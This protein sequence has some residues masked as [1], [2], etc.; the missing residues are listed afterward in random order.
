MKCLDWGK[1]CN[2]CIWGFSFPTDHFLIWHGLWPLCGVTQ[3]SH[4]M[5]IFAFFILWK[6]TDQSFVRVWDACLWNWRGAC[7]MGFMCPCVCRSLFSQSL[8]KVPALGLAHA[9]VSVCLWTFI[10]E[11]M[12]KVF[13]VSVHK[14]IYLSRTLRGFPIPPC[15]Q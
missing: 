4:K 9:L 6:A 1:C 3:A 7:E 13:L 12:L 11:P 14:R 15:L 8:A 10:T 2:F 5:F